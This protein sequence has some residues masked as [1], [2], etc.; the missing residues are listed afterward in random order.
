MAQI[1]KH[2]R[3]SRAR[4]HARFALGLTA[5]GVAGTAALLGPL[6]PRRRPV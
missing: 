1:R 3:T 4:K 6:P 5:I 2:S